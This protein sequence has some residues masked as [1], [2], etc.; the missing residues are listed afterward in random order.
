MIHRAGRTGRKT[1]E[2]NAMPI[3]ASRV[4]AGQRSAGPTL[5]M[6]AGRRRLCTRHGRTGDLQGGS[7]FKRLIPAGVLIGLLA[8]MAAIAQSVPGPGVSRGALLYSTHC[9]ACHN[10]QMHWR[11]AKV[12]KDWPTLKAEVRRWQAAARLGWSEDDIAEVARHLNALHYGYVEPQAR[13]T[14]PGGPQARG[15]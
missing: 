11:D 9:I 14:A 15:P 8:A 4:D 3:A 1:V 10:M 12:V 2:R 7:M 6:L 13:W 5:T